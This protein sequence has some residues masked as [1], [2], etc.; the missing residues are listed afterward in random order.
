MKYSEKNNLNVDNLRET[1]KD[2]IKKQQIDIKI[3]TKI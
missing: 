2:F 3:A 1:R